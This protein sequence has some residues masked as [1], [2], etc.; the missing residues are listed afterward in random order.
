MDAYVTEIRKLKNKFLRLEIHHVIPDNNV[1]SNVLSKLGFDRANVLP[2]VFVHELHHP[3][4]KAPDSSSIAQG[5]KEPNREVLM[6]K[7]DWRVTFIDYIQEHKQPPGIDPK[8]AEATRILRR[9]K[10][11]VLVGGNLYKRG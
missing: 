7:V 5:P 2:G 9:S 11:Y 1:G 4:I 8:S 10:G 3:S 6:I